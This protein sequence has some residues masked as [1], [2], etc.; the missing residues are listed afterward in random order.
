PVTVPPVNDKNSN[1]VL[2]TTEANIDRLLADAKQKAQEAKAEET[3]VGKNGVVT[4]EE[5]AQL[6]QAIKDAQDAK[7]AVDA[8]IAKLPKGSY[9]TTQEGESAKIVIPN[10]LDVTP[11]PTGKP[12]VVV[13]SGLDADS[14]D[15]IDKAELGESDGQPNPVTVKISFG[16]VQNVKAGDILT[17]KITVGDKVYYINSDKSLTETQPAKGYALTADDIRDGISLN[18]PVQDGF[19]GQLSVSDVTVKDAENQG[20]DTTAEQQS[21]QLDITDAPTVTM[22]L[23]QDTGSSKT[24]K[25]TNNGELSFTPPQGYVIDSITVNNKPVQLV[26]GNKITLP[27]GQYDE[28][29]VVVTIRN[30]TTGRTATIPNSDRYVVDTT[31]PSEPQIDAPAGKDTTIVLP[32]DADIG[33]VFKVKITKPGEVANEI[34]YRKEENAWVLQGSSVEGVNLAN[35]MITIARNSTPVG[36]TINATVT[37]VAGNSA[38]ATEATVKE[39]PDQDKD[40]YTDDE[41]AKAGSNPNLNSST[42]KT[43]AEEAYEKAKQAFDDFNAKKTEF[44]TNGFTQNEVNELSKM[45]QPLSSLKQEAI[46]AAELVHETDGQKALIDNITALSA[47][48]PERNNEP[49]DAYWTSRSKQPTL[50]MQQM[51]PYYGFFSSGKTLNDYASENGGIVKIAAQDLGITDSFGGKTFA[52]KLA[53]TSDAWTKGFSNDGSV[54]ITEYRVDKDGNMEIRI[55]AEAAKK[56]DGTTNQ[57]FKVFAEDGTELTLSVPFRNPA[58]EGN[59]VKILD[60][61]IYDNKQPLTGAVEKNGITNDG[62]WSDI[63]VQVNKQAR[64]GSN[65]DSWRVKLEIIDTTDSNRVVWNQEQ[66]VGGTGKA[67]MGFNA[68]GFNPEDGHTYI[69]RASSYDTNNTNALGTYT[70]SDS[71][72]NRVTL[73]T[74]PPAVEHHIY[75]DEAGKLHVEFTFKED[76]LKVWRKDG[77]LAN[78]E[79][80]VLQNYS[81]AVDVSQKDHKWSTTIRDGESTFVFYDKEGNSQIVDLLKDAQVL[82]LARLTTDMTK[83]IGPRNWNS[84]SNEEQRNDT[85]ADRSMKTS[86]DKDNIIILRQKQGG[87]GFGGFIDGGTELEGYKATLQTYDHDDFIDAV[88]MGGHT[89]VITGAGNDLFVLR[90][91]MSGYGPAGYPGGSFDGPQR[92]LMGAGNDTF[93]INGYFKDESIGK[94]SMNN[95]TA[96]VSMGDGNDTISIAWSIEADHDSDRPYSNYFYLGAGN[97]KMTVGQHITDTA[98]RLASNIIDLGSGHDILTVKGNLQDN[99]L[100]LSKESSEITVGSISGL[101]NVTMLLGDGDDVLKVNTDMNY[102]QAQDTAIFKEIYQASLSFNGPYKADVNSWYEESKE[103]LASL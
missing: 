1:G 90:N 11:I 101:A 103:A 16:D 48:V 91:G 51:G 73:D 75:A 82:R 80:D 9:R 3:K 45:W 67:V 76:S 42:P 63:R 78:P 36:T 23:T 81:S 96:K 68:N 13:G 14:N 12:A 31:T 86:V 85:G 47:E 102:N 32:T 55:D 2:D 29:S 89:D 43:L 35:G 21:V 10:T 60:V 74:T 57:T 72:E 34:E 100:I 58:T 99:A 39:I 37:D 92:I 93:A 87:D 53:A 38:S 25:I 17:G 59:G 5:K 33:D 84:D 46:N 50:A 61:T 24:D 18:V 28:G 83:D 52:T 79:T 54:S 44:A 26:E 77:A 69:L 94:T 95:T 49:G 97:D 65:L 20:N 8:E 88:G 56:V 41:E 22:E 98:P 4:A 30:E 27:E 19:Q 6:D 40:G 7:A 70:I 64:S 15:V 62:Q 66:T 71:V